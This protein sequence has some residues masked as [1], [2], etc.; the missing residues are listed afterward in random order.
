MKNKSLIS[1]LLLA[2]SI[3]PLMSHAQT[4]GK[5]AGNVLDAQTGEPLA[6]AQVIIEGKWV[7]G[8]EVEMERKMGATVD[9]DGDFFII[10]IPPE[11]Y[12]VSIQMMGYETMKLTD[13]RVSVNR[14]FVITA[15]LKPGIMEGE[16]IVVTASAVEMKKDQTSSIRNISSKDIEVLPVENISQVISMQPGVV[17]GHF[18]G[19]RA[20]EVSYLLDGLQVDESFGQT[21][22]TVTVNTEV[23]EEIEVITGTFNAEYGKAMSGI[24]N[25]ITKEG[26][27]TFTGYGY[28]NTGNYLTSHNNIFVG[29]DNSDFS[30]RKD[31]RVGLSG[32]I[33]SH[34]LNFVINGRYEDNKGYLNGIHRF[35]VDDYSDFTD[36]DSENWYSE[37]NG[38]NKYVP[39]SWG[40]HTTLF[41]KLTFRP[42]DQIKTSLMFTWNDN[43]S[44]G[45][46]HYY[47]YNPDGTA[48]YYGESQMAAFQFNHMLSS[49]AF[50]EF[51]ASYIDNYT[52]NYMYKNPY[53]ERYVHDLYSRGDG[54]GFV[55]GGQQKHY[56]ERTIKDINLKL[57]LVWQ[58]NKTHSIKTGCLYTQHDVDN[59]SA[60][61]RNIYYGTE[62]EAQY[63]YDPEAKKRKYLYYEPTVLPDSSVYS[64]I[65]K[66]TP[67]ELSCYIQDKMEF[68]EMVINLGLR[69]DYFNPNTLYPSQLRNPANQLSFP[70]N[71]EKM[72]TYLKAP[73]VSQFSPRLGISYQLGKT[74]LLRFAYGHFFQMPPLYAL[75]QNHSLLISPSDY[76]T[77]MGNPLIK[78]QKTIQ[79]EVGLW[80]QVTEGLSYE[81]AIFY[82]DIYDLLSAKVIT[83][84]NQIRYGLYSNK[85]YGNVRGLEFKCDF[86][87]GS[88]HAN[89][90]YTLQYTRGNADD[91]TYTFNRAGISQDPV[92]KMIPMSWDQRHTMNVSAG[93]NKKDFGTTMTLFYNSGTPY[94]WYPLSESVKSRVN[95]YPNNSSKPTQIRADLNA[96]YYLINHERM[97]VKL[98][99]LVYNLFDRLNENSVYSSTGRAY[100]T[101]TREVDIESHRS[102]FNDYKD[103]IENPAMYAAPRL[104][105]I[106]FGIEF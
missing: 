53:D 100:T 74:A 19:G 42:L 30:R 14:T 104:V 50:Y 91:P 7:D 70:D 9:L 28:V 4:T 68:D 83:T 41:G 25:V 15:E 46:D 105:R 85:D 86:V 97:K 57:D 62:L 77:R 21:G 94:T 27:Q 52:G 24:V 1:I 79:Y 11:S 16:E 54:P 3:L 32:P 20:N 36:Q 81:V 45:Y 82:K 64:D 8:V 96:Y 12:T 98:M 44:Q 29:L 48:T 61:I 13:V 6:G 10:N 78:P 72:S 87:S 69:Y 106:G 18:R 37:H 58:I 73:F 80:Q 75:Y 89:L 31:Y 34:R 39:M 38:D 23:V 5:I 93:Y 47:K 67:Y 56:V 2:F 40:K 76:S 63:E 60:S 26:G 17:V 33:F 92:N 95:L 43:E 84:Y 103:S 22:R 90:N 66:V 102:D 51:K 55:T 71:P 65:Y 88:L 35:N 101:I 49:T 99:L 59:M